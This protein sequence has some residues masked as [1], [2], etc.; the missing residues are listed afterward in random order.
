V[1]L[2]FTLEKEK[3]TINLSREVERKLEKGEYSIRSG[4]SRQ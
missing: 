1:F 3:D 2:A 4:A